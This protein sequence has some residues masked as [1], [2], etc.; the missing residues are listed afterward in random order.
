[1]NPHFKPETYHKP[2]SLDEVS[3]L[4]KEGGTII[5]GGTDLLVNKP[6]ETS[7]L[8]DIN[9]LPLSYIKREGE[10]LCIGAT[11]SFAKLAQSY[12]MEK[13]PYQVIKESAKELGHHNLRNVATVGGNLCNGV[14]S[15]DSP[16]SLI[17]LDAEAVI[18]SNG[19]ERVVPLSEFFTFVRETV[20]Q[21]GEFL[22]EIRV[23]AQPANTG[24]SF[25]KLGRT[26]VDIALVNA[27]CRISL[28][29]DTIRDT[30]IVLGAVAPTPIRATEAGSLL[31][32]KV[33]SEELIEQAATLAAEATK[34]IS[35]VRASAEY[36]KAMSKVLVKRAIEK[37]HERA[38]EAS[39]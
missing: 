11:T 24:A 20:L 7:S 8:I 9:G 10:N 23:P 34:P 5:A 31:N 28:D 30:L 1:M 26:K 3:G 6:Q 33:L 27:A 16:V 22:K 2:R 38:R 14:P 32:G 13:H 36:R 29:G 12:E 18:W 4:L 17:A 19:S 15:A 35:D 21:P 39:Q 25:Q 37:A